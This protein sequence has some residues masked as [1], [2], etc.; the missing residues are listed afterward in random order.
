MRFTNGMKI[1]ITAFGHTQFSVVRADHKAVVDLSRL[2][3]GVYPMVIRPAPKR[4]N[5][6]PAL[7]IW[8][9]PGGNVLRRFRFPGLPVVSGIGLNT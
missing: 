7:R 3:C 2:I 4:A 6:A 5:F 9:L 8:S 1:S